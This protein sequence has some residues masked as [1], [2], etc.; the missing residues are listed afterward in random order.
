VNTK[1]KGSR[2]ELECQKL[3]EALGYTVTKAGASL[4]VFDLIA[5]HP[6]HIRFIQ[7]KANRRPGSV[8]M[9]TLRNTVVPPG[10][11]KEVWVRKDG[12]RMPIV[13]VL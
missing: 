12:D 3:L 7:V 11:S 6:T 9:E 5:V 8:E 13:E 1:R 2:I 4:G 10:C